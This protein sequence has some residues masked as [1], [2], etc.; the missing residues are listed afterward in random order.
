M[1]YDRVDELLRERHMSRR[2]LAIKAGLSFNTM[3]GRFRRRSKT[4]PVEDIEA[5][6][7]ALG[8]EPQEI[9]AHT[10]VY[11]HR[12]IEDVL[13]EL[14]DLVAVRIGGESERGKHK[15]ADLLQG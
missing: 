5:I 15:L 6:A 14:I 8:V 9:S 1:D 7:D 2:A 13:Q 10:I 11:K 12:T 3:S 4:I